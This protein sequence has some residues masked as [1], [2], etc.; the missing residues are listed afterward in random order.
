MSIPAFGFIGVSAAPAG[1]QSR[2]QEHAGGLDGAPS[3]PQATVGEVPVGED[4][5]SG[6][7]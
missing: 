4:P 2:Q 3:E 7:N 1:A 6:A 5:H